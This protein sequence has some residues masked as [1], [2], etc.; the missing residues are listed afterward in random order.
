MLSRSAC[1]FAI[2]SSLLACLQACTGVSTDQLLDASFLSKSLKTFQV[3]APPSIGQGVEYEVIVNSLVGNQIYANA[4]STLAWSVKQGNGTI[5]VVS[6]PGFTNGI[7]KV[8]LR[9]DNAA[10]AFGQSE[11][12]I[13]RAE[14][15]AES[16]Q[17]GLSNAI[18]AVGPATLNGFQITAPS[19]AMVSVDFPITIKAI[20]TDNNTY[21]A[22]TGCVTLT[23]SALGGTTGAL[24]VAI[25]CGF[26]SGVAT[27]NINFNMAA[28]S[29][30][31]TA[32]DSVSGKSG[33]TLVNIMPTDFSLIAIPIPA[34]PAI[35][36][37]WT[38]VSAASTYNIYRTDIV[39]ALATLTSATLTF[40]DTTAVIGNTYSYRVD[41]L[42]ASAQLIKQVTYTIKLNACTLLMAAVSTDTT[43]DKNLSPYC[44]VGNVTVTGAKL[45]VPAGVIVEFAAASGI[46]IGAGSTLVSQ[47][48]SADPVIWTSADS[49]PVTPAWNG[50]TF[51]STAIPSTMTVTL[52][53][54]E[55]TSEVFTSGA[56]I[57]NSVIEFAGSGI[58]TN[59]PLWLEANLFRLNK[60]ANGA[61]INISFSS[62]AQW[63]VAR[64]NSF[65]GNTASGGNGGD[66]YNN[67]GFGH[68]DLRGNGFV[69]S[70]A[71]SNGGA[72]YL[73]SAQNTLASNSFE[74]TSQTPSIGNGGAALLSGS[75]QVIKNNTFTGGLAWNGFFAI[76]SGS[77][78]L[79]SGNTF[80]GTKANGGGAIATTGG[81]TNLTIT[82]NTFTNTSSWTGGALNISGS[83][84]IVTNNTFTGTYIFAATCCFFNGGGGG[85]YISGSGNTISQ[86]TFTNTYIQSGNSYTGGAI[87]ASAD[88]TSITFNLFKNTYVGTG[89]PGASQGGGGAIWVQANNVTIAHNTFD[90]TSVLGS[91]S[92]GGWRMTGGALR[93][94]GNNA[95]IRLNNFTTTTVTDGSAN[96]GAIFVEGNNATIQH[97]N[98]FGATIF[99][100]STPNVLGTTLNTGSTLTIDTGTM[101]L[102]SAQNW[103]GT[104]L[105]AFST[106]ASATPA[107]TY[108]WR[109]GTLDPTINPAASAWPLCSGIFT[110]QDCVGN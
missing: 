66:I 49:N 91:V 46:T 97:N 13:L 10:L 45:T 4:N 82:G 102:V 105:S 40:L 107:N 62:N 81:I 96:G 37:N 48:S 94:I 5:T 64:S 1:I 59:V 7:Q 65:V 76:Q 43:L 86:N 14:N 109:Q 19:S 52:S 104:D 83:G 54:N 11:V 18:T 70:L 92:A 42:N 72:L 69:N 103:W 55:A 23:P 106:C 99:G 75:N 79:M 98:F 28:A 12:V 33:T 3:V 77:N 32:T 57:A 8:R 34:S 84:I 56:V 2:T 9:Y 36:L 53:G 50:I 74:N 22:F 20:G 88:T 27:L 41:A 101:P 44:P 21:A 51:A 58:T 63:L 100:S 60:A 89:N 73:N 110:N 108:C 25:V 38:Q 17:F 85:I 24:S 29:L 16:S 6:A 67:S 93:V 71:A 68:V 26:S 31:L 35:R 78:S 15:A 87:M 47:G 61:A 30:I 80:T 95:I 39:P 90:T